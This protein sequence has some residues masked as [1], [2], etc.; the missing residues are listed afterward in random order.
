MHSQ[1]LA[2]L[3]SFLLV[4]ACAPMNAPASGPD[5]PETALTGIIWKAE[6][7]GGGGIIDRSH[8]TLMLGPENRASGSAGCN[9]YIAH[10]R[11]SGKALTITRIASTEK[12]CAPALMLQEERYT[13]LLTR[14]AHWRIEPTGALVLTATD[15]ASLRFFPEEPA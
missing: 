6:D 11:L 1:L 12:G 5:A 10:Y 3:S 7:I 2:A 13:A 4:A 15:G 9:R 14:V 8:I